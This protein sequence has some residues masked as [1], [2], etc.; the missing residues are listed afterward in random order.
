MDEAR[1]AK[2]GRDGDSLRL[3]TRVPTGEAPGWQLCRPAA[4]GP[5]SGQ[6]EKPAAHS[7]GFLL[8]QW[9][10]GEVLK[11]PAG[12]HHGQSSLGATVS[13]NSASHPILVFRRRAVGPH[14]HTFTWG[15]DGSIW[16]A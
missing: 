14:V 2:K 5:E 10:L 7:L 15:R 9:A 4:P 12:L 8:A 13:P 11:L 1:G 6:A 16:E 3:L